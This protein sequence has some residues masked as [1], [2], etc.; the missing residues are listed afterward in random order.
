MPAE[1][2]VYLIAA[3]FTLSIVGLVGAA[4]WYI[5]WIERKAKEKGICR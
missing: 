3:S 5:R 2:Q 1:V 4:A